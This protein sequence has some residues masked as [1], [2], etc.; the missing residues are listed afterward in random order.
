M[1]KLQKILFRGYQ[2]LL[3]GVLD[4]HSVGAGFSCQTPNLPTDANSYLK[5]RR[6]HIPLTKQAE[7]TTK[8]PKSYVLCNVQAL[9]MHLAD[10]RPIH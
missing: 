3:S 6:L 8:L 5:D 9:V 4:A 10:N 2:A 1:T 7:Y